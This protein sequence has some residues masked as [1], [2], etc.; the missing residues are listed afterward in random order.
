MEEVIGFL[1]FSLGASLGAGL[2]GSIGGGGRPVLRQVLKVGIQT[3]DTVAGAAEAGARAARS[4]EA[5]LVLP[6]SASPTTRGRSRRRA[7]PQR[8]AIARE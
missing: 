6:E 4:A 7:E 5:E 3:W 2:V 8:I 1:G